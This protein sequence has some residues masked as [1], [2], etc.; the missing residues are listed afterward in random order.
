MCFARK[1]YWENAGAASYGLFST[2][3]R[4]A[5]FSG[6]RKSRRRAIDQA[7][8]TNRESE[9]TRDPRTGHALAAKAL[10]EVALRLQL[11]PRSPRFIVDYDF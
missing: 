9:P 7:E 3:H 1:A 10:A 6:F 8:T 2:L 5:R 11:S 4:I